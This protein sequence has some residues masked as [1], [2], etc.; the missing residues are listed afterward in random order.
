MLLV[1]GMYAYDVGN[2]LLYCR[3]LLI[4]KG[5]NA[6]MLVAELGDWWDWKRVESLTPMN[7]R[8]SLSDEEPGYGMGHSSN[9]HYDRDGVSLHEI[10]LDCDEGIEVDK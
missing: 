9:R 5:V 7:N 8:S 3:D 10:T 6:V 1:N 4:S 2:K